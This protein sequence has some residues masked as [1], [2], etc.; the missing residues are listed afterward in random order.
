M[1][2]HKYKHTYM[3]IENGSTIW[4]DILGVHYLSESKV[5]VTSDQVIFPLVIELIEVLPAIERDNYTKKKLSFMVI[6][7][8]SFLN[9]STKLRGRTKHRETD[10]GRRKAVKKI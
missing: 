10:L 9:V 7:T 6:F 4:P 3:Y 8:K 5:C 2:T 1:H